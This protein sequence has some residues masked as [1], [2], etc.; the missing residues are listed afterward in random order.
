MTQAL[1]QGE[2]LYVTDDQRLYIGNGSTLGGVQITG[3]TDE[4]A[5][6]AAAE[7]FANG[8]HTGITFAYNDAAG[9][10]SAVVD[11]LNYQGTIG[12]AAFKG[13][14]VGDD[15][16]ILVDAVSGRIVGPVFANVTG[17]VTGDVSGNVTGNLLGNVIGSVTGDI[18]GSVFGD[19]S[20][21]MVD[22]VDLKLSNGIV[23]LSENNILVTGGTEPFA[24]TSGNPYESLIIGD[25][26]N[27]CVLVNYSDEALAILVGRTL[28]PFDS[29]SLQIR[30]ARGTFE[31][32]TV[33]SP[34]DLIAPIQGYAYDG[35]GY[36]S[37]GSFGMATDPST[38]ISTG[39]VGGAFFISAQKTTGGDSRLLFDSAGIL[40][41]PI[42]KPG[43]FTDTTRNALTPAVGMIIYN[44]TS[45]KFQGYQNTGGVTLEWVDLS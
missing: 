23:T 10:I 44:T 4:D 36:T 32:P 15:S 33:N 34:G 41:A 12:A 24:L 30:N 45:N 28:G 22:S 11:L 19:D 20:T 3:Y 42:L 43:S 5:Q 9:S 35:V 16:T 37:V 27:P 29:A 39:S 17:N 13:T 6:D 8:T 21:I 2:L 1:A 7:L 40:F 25:E 38:A 18:K 26:S 31:V 14:V